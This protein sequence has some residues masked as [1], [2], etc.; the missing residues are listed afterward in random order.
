[1]EL[2]KLTSSG[3]VTIP[4]EIRKKLKLKEG[5]KVMFLEDG[6]RITLVNSS[7]LA[8]EKLQQAMEGAAK[9][10]GINT[11][12]DVVALCKDIRKEQYNKQYAD[13]D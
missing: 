11:E 6:N 5:D 13:N 9:Q 12:D 2:A 1:M 3:Q 4:V 8:I 7:L 10:A